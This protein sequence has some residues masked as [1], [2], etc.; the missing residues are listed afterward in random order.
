MGPVLGAGPGGVGE[1]V[2]LRA[3]PQRRRRVRV[4]HGGRRLVVPAEEETGEMFAALH[5]YL[6]TD[7]LDLNTRLIT[8]V[9]N[10]NNTLTSLLYY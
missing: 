9:N 1:A 10:K 8:S 4:V 2:R 3:G 7:S 6:E 5:Q